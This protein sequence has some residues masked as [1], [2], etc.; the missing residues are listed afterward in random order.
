MVRRAGSSSSKRTTSASRTASAS[1]AGCRSTT[2]SSCSAP[3]RPGADGTLEAQGLA[4][5]EAILAGIPVIA[6]AIGGIPDAIRHDETGLLVE[7]AS[8]T[9][10][11]GAVRRL[12]DD[13]SLAARLAREG[14][15]L[16]M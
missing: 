5:A 14:R 9:Q 12:V 7:P 1:W 8:P 15:A 4:I 2:C 10:L 16:A 6:T 11:A 3:S 13:A